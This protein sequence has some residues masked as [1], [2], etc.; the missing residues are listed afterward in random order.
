MTAR[1]Q[2]PAADL[3]LIHR[4]FG[5]GDPGSANQQA[6]FR[7]WFG[8]RPSGALP[9]PRIAAGKH[10]LVG[11]RTPGLCTCCK[12]TH[13]LLDHARVWLDGDGG[14]VY[15]AEPYD[16][17]GAE[18]AELAAECAGLGL[19]VCVTGTSPYF[20]GRTTLIVIQ[21]ACDDAVHRLHTPLRLAEVRGE[22]PGWADHG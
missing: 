1:T 2:D 19:D 16:F 11:T 9:C 20:P 7:E 14:H 8:W 13:G 3:K 21:K 12:Y 15:T 6:R 18:F 17:D 10:C 4:T 5:T 22:L